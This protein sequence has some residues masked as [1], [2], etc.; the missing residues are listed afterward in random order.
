MNSRKAKALRA[1]AAQV[2]SVTEQ[3]ITPTRYGVRG[4]CRKR[5]FY[6]GLDLNGNFVPV[7]EHLVH[8]QGGTVVLLP[9]SLRFTSQTLKKQ[10]K[11][12]AA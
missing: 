8:A 5:M 6:N 4:R 11:R 3:P 10:T 12:R 2:L 1:L 9:G 7:P